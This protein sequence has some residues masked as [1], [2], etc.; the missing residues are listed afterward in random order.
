[1]VLQEVKEEEPGRLLLTY[2]HT[3]EIEGE[4]ESACVAENL[5]ILVVQWYP[6]LV[7][8]SMVRRCLSS[9]SAAFVLQVHNA[10]SG[11]HQI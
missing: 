5:G 8:V 1:V 6:G 4:E 7:A 2:S 3:I 10:A 9:L 11:R